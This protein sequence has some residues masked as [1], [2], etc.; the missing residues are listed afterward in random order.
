MFIGKKLNEFCHF[1][2]NPDNNLEKTLHNRLVQIAFYE[3]KWGKISLRFKPE[4]PAK[5]LLVSFFLHQNRPVF[6]GVSGGI[7]QCNQTASFYFR[8]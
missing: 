6:L 7:T 8:N 2:G 1:F 3:S 4:S 5:G